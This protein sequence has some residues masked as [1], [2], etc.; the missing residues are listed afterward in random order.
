MPLE[1]APVENP[2]LLFKSLSLK[3]ERHKAGAHETWDAPIFIACDKRD[4]GIYASPANGSDDPEFGEM[5]SDRVCGRSQLTNE[6]MPRSMQSQAGLLLWRFDR[7]E[8]HIGPLHSFAN[9]FGISRVILLAFD[10]RLHIGRRHVIEEGAY[11]G[12]IG[13]CVP[14][15]LTVGTPAVAFNRLAMLGIN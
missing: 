1:K 12:Q 2:D 9:R 14:C 3:A 15:R 11:R 10:V 4:Q 13:P 6:Q 8:T 5:R 7:Y